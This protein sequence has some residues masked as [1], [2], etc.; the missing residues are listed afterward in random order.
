MP[1][2]RAALMRPLAALAAPGTFL[3]CKLSQLQETAKRRVTE[4]ELK[5]LNHKIDKLLLKLDESETEPAKSRDEECVVCISSKATMQTFPCGHCVVCRKCFIKTIQMT[6]A[7]RALPL[8]CVLCRERVIRLKQTFNCSYAMRLPLSVSQYS[9]TSSVTS[10][11]D[12][13]LP[14]SSSL[15]S[16]SSGCSVVSADSQ[17]SRLSKSSL[18]SGASSVSSK[19]RVTFAVSPLLHIP[20]QT[21]QSTPGLTSS[22]VQGSRPARREQT[23]SE[24]PIRRTDSRGKVTSVMLTDRRLP[25]IKESHREPSP[26]SSSRPCSPAPSSQS[27]PVRSIKSAA[28][29]VRR[30]VPVR[31][32]GRRRAPLADD[33]ETERLLPDDDDE[34]TRTA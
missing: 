19:K 9:M 4:R 22:P 12:W 18:R 16:V 28:A 26:Q 15:Y 3:F 33:D 11:P 29:P 14:S 32:V 6:V 17:A 24:Q 5:Q 25:P 8:R 27:A 20:A 1:R 23:A 21:A 13:D 31:R 2:R 7:Q 34:V 30:L 10:S